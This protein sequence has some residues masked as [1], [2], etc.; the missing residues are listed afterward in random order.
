MKFFI[1]SINIQ[2]QWER[3]QECLH[4]D[5]SQFGTNERLNIP[6]F[7]KQQLPTIKVL[8]KKV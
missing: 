3:M 7:H 8:A 5:A 6:F 4:P 1:Q 2:K